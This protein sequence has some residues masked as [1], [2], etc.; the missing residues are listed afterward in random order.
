MFPNVFPKQIANILSLSRI[1][2][3]AIIFWLTPYT[4]NLQ[5]ILVV[6]IY[7]A[8][9]FTDFADGWIARKLKVV[10]DFGKLLDPLADK[11]LV[12]VLLPLLEMQ[13]ISSFPVFII[14]AREFA[15]M[16][17]RVW[18]AKDGTIV[19][20]RYSGKIKTTITLIVC[21]IL[22]A[23]VPVTPLIL[24]AFLMPIELLRLWVFSWPA[25]VYNV[26]IYAMV[27]VTIWSFFEYTEGFMW[28]QYVRRIGDEDKAKRM[29][30]SLVPNTFSLINLLS[31]V[32]AIVLGF[33]EHYS[34]AVFFIFLGMICD[35]L[36]GKLARKLDASSVLGAKLDSKADVLTFGWAPAIII[37]KVVSSFPEIY[38][39]ALPLHK[40]LGFLMGAMY[41]VCVYYRLRRF[42]D[43]GHGDFFDGI[44]SPIGAATCMVAIL[45]PILSYPWF[46]LLLTI[47]ISLL[48]ISKIPYAHL[49]FASKTGL[50][51]F[52]KPVQLFML[53]CMIHIIARHFGYPVLGML[54]PAELLF[55]FILI[56]VCSPISVKPPII[57]HT[58]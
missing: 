33:F 48:M 30:R 9:C 16:A 13:T 3:V 27:I 26:L 15:I 41:F 4:N 29:L 49:D 56:Y 19:A 8:I 31:G 42:D 24:P 43:S 38:H 2:G 7:V 17:L 25:T 51:Y 39:V 36:D 50:R 46:F 54:Y 32:I 37:F 10:S 22:F 35:S 20:A 11:I 58:K 12:L 1:V 55:G 14:L 47:A 45:S 28:E 40:V 23:R 57:T 53:V 18:S 44:P 34:F 5:E 21:G 6:L 52:I